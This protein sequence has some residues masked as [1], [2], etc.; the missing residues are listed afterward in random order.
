MNIFSPVLLSRE[1]WVAYLQS[2]VDATGCDS[3]DEPVWNVLRTAEEFTITF[4]FP[5]EYSLCLNFDGCENAVSLIHIELPIC[6]LA[7]ERLGWLDCHSMSCVFRWDEFLKVITYLSANDPDRPAWIPFLL[8]QPF[9]G[10]TPNN[11]GE[12]QVMLRNNLESSEMFTEE[13][14]QF[15]V[16]DAHRC[17]RPA[18]RWIEDDQ[19]GWLA[20]GEHIGSMRQRSMEGKFNFALVSAFFRALEQDY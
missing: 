13:E 17:V 9:V 16:E 7:R 15:I 10:L 2:C 5:Q 6:D 1:F 12:F 11:V 19:L 3:L 8:F 4:R 14:V 20:E 18:L